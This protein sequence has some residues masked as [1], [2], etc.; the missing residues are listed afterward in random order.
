MLTYSMDARGDRPRYLYLYEMIKADIQQGKLK[1]GERPLIL[2]EFGGI[3]FRIPEHSAS[4][5]VYGYGKCASAEAYA[6]AMKKLYEEQLL[7]AAAAGLSASVLTQLSDV[8]EETNGLLTWD[9]KV[10][11]LPDAALPRPELS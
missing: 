6:A 9:R 8:E 3:S 1:P 11:K 7:P 2:S 10:K 4:E 5:K